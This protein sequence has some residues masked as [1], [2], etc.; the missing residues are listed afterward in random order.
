MNEQSWINDKIDR[1]EWGPGP[2]VGEPD[3]VQWKDDATGLDCLANRHP[4]SGNWCGYVGVPPGHALHGKRYDDVHFDGEDGY[5][6]V[7][8]GLTFADECEKA[9]APCRG[10]CHIPQ[11]GEPEHL[12]WF[13]FDCHHSGDVAPGS[14]K[15]DRDHG[16]D[17]YAFN[18][19]YRPLGYVQRECA[20]FAAQIVAAFPK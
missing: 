16:F 12:W 11:P 6:D 13:G 17:S 14:I 4:R 18:A 2:W 9:D 7:H 3:K 20:K 1:S 5:P 10:I 8:G 15:W 19:S